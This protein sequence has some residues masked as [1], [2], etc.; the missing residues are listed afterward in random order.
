ML[1]FTKDD[2]MCDDDEFEVKGLEPEKSINSNSVVQSSSNP[3]LLEQVGEFPSEQVRELL[4]KRNSMLEI[5]AIPLEVNKS[6][7]S[8]SHAFSSVQE[9]EIEEE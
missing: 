2:P 9:N 4:K 5:G 6:Q 7:T 8:K 1:N 3:N